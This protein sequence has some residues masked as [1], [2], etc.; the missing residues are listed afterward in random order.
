M[1]SDGD[2]GVKVNPIVNHRANKILR[3]IGNTQSNIIGDCFI[4]RCLDD[5][6]VDWERLDFLLEDLCDDA[7]WILAAVL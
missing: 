7:P 3:L 1:Y 2:A 4:G 6:R 5:E